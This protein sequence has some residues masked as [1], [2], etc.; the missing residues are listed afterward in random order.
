MEYPGAIYHGDR[1]G[2]IFKDNRDR[3]A[4]IE[5]LATTMPRMVIRPCANPEAIDRAATANTL[6]PGTTDKTNI[7]PNNDAMFPI[8]ISFMD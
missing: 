5:A 4:F 2:D 7:V 8:V 6:G 1:R 3:Q